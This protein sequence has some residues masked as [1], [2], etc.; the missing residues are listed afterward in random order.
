MASSTAT[1]QVLQDGP[2]NC[3]VKIT[4]VNVGQDEAYNIKV[5]PQDLSPIFDNYF[6]ANEVRIGQIFYSI[7]DGMRVDLCWDVAGASPTT[8]GGGSIIIESLS[9]RGQNFPMDRTGPFVNPSNTSSGAIGL[10]TI[11][12]GSSTTNYTIGL[13]LLK[14]FNQARANALAGNGP[15]F[16]FQLPANSQNIPLM[17]GLG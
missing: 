12:T 4:G 17:A 1:V 7:S 3:F 2:R 16:D 9:G 6:K 13:L 15:Y 10:Q 8:T 5:I 11:G 14:T